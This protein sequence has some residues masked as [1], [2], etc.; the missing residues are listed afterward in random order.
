MKKNVI[1][2]L[3]NGTGKVRN[4]KGELVL[5]E[6]TTKLNS[7]EYD[8]TEKHEITLHEG[9][10]NDIYYV[11]GDKEG[12]YCASE[13]RY[14]T[15]NYKALLFTAI[16]IALNEHKGNDFEINLGINLPLTV[17][18]ERKMEQ[19]IKAKFEAKNFEFKVDG[20][21]YKIKIEKVVVMPENL[22]VGLLKQEDIKY[23]N[24]FF[25]LGNG[26]IDILFTE[27]TK[28]GAIK[29]EY[30]GIDTLISKMCEK[31]GARK[32]QIRKYWNNLSEISVK[33]NQKNLNEIKEATLI[34]YVSD[35]IRIAENVNGGD[36]NDVSRIYLL[37]GGAKLIEETMKVFINNEI[38]VF[39]NP[40][41]ANLMCLEEMFK[42]I[43]AA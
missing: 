43:I 14:T 27:G 10:N 1:I 30:I 18:K 42:K 33:G 41:F 20:K 31:S 6:A 9:F 13:R 36:L 11:I 19:L 22:V 8:M 38:K 3:G 32:N 37:G 16:G 2:D 39:D 4:A 21:E 15:E 40:Q 7:N 28:L 5:F 17:Y 24:L 26:T 35:L 23:K 25:D 29:T 12:E 34:D